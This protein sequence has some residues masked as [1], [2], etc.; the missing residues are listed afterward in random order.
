MRRLVGVMDQPLHFPDEIFV[1][2]EPAPTSTV[3]AFVRLIRKIAV[4]NRPVTPTQR[5]QIML[6]SFDNPA[7]GA[8]QNGGFAV[9]D[10]APGLTGRRKSITGQGPSFSKVFRWQPSDPSAPMPATV[11]LAGSFTDWQ[12]EAMERDAVTNTWQLTLHG[13][14]GNRTHR[15]MLLLMATAAR[16]ARE[17][18]ARKLIWSVYQANGLATVFY[19]KLGAQRITD[20][21]FMKLPVDTL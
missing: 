14:A 5:E 15:Y 10:Y 20:L 12:L 6:D 7:G 18:G 4:R 11:E 17:A 9:L 19:E 3:S 21:F 1:E 2:S 13:I 8:C 16:I